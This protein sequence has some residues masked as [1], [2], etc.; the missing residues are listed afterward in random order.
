MNGVLLCIPLRNLLVFA[1]NKYF[2]RMSGRSIPLRTAGCEKVSFCNPYI[3]FVN[4]TSN[5]LSDSLKVF[6]F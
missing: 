4:F 2:L 5:E 6:V 1:F 3:C